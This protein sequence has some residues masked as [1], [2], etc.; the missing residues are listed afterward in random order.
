MLPLPG[1]DRVGA[2][3][4]GNDEGKGTHQSDSGDKGEER[5][6]GKG[7]SVVGVAH[8]REVRQQL[9]PQRS[10]QPRALP[11]DHARPRP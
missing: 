5:Q 6:Q 2:S 7:M 11:G 1:S 3:P 9:R 10:T 4:E 8:K